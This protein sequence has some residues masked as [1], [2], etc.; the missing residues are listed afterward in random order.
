[1]RK[2][3]SSLL[4][5]PYTA[6]SDI[7]GPEAMEKK[8]SARGRQLPPKLPQ[9]NEDIKGLLGPNGGFVISRNASWTKI[10]VAPENAVIQRLVHGEARLGGVFTGAGCGFVE[11]QLE[12]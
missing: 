4:A 7:Q 3:E 2:R 8:D 9:G 1:M 11:K 5:A 12:N 10:K 6:S